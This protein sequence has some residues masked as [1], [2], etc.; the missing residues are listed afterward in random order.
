[1]FTPVLETT[2]SSRD[3]LKYTHVIEAPVMKP[4]LIFG[5]LASSEN[6]PYAQNCKTLNSSRSN[7]SLATVH[8]RGSKGNLCNI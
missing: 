2:H 3:G 7:I 4:P 8:K 1:M 5:S 6:Y